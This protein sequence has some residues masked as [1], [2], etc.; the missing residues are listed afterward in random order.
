MKHTFSHRTRTLIDLLGSSLPHGI[1][2]H[3]QKGVGL[4][5]VARK[6]AENNDLTF[7]LIT[8]Q[9][10]KTT[11]G[12]EDIRTLRD[13][14]KT[15]HNKLFALQGD[16]TP[17]AQNALLKLLEEPNNST[18][19]VILSYKPKSLLPT[20]QSRAESHLVHPL[21]RQ[22]SER[23][24]DQLDIQDA[25]K[26]TQILFLAS[27]LPAEISQLATDEDYFNSR[28]ARLK[29]A[30]KILQSDQYESL[31]I[32]NAYNDRDAA[33]ALCDDILNLLKQNI[34]DDDRVIEKLRAFSLAYD[35][36]AKNVNV[37]LALASAVV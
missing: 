15:N 33:K 31:Q 18:Y 27:G 5:T 4:T 1:I 20:I 29:D 35:R 2:L 34:Q 37:R 17:T 21:S 9:K 36:L 3:G 22:E 14:A 32:V 7:R 30:M 26:R 13:N 11:I 24:L 12:V 6:V 25:T 28:A 16:M 10:D 19:I 8:P 23:L